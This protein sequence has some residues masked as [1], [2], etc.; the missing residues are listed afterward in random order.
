[1]QAVRASATLEDIYRSYWPTRLASYFNPNAVV[2][3]RGFLEFVALLRLDVRTPVCYTLK[4]LAEEMRVPVLAC[5]SDDY[6]AGYG[7]PWV[8]ASPRGPL[9]LVPARIAG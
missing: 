6:F 8:E 2:E 1:M 9:R 7:T 4:R 3:L 5:P